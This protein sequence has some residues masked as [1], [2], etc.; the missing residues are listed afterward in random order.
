MYISWNH[1]RD[2][3][4]T[5]GVFLWVLES[6]LL[7]LFIRSL[8]SGSSSSTFL[9]SGAETSATCLKSTSTAAATPG[10]FS[11][12]VCFR[13]DKNLPN[14]FSFSA[15]FTGSLFIFCNRVRN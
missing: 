8:F 3:I 6:S 10:F 7:I 11:E 14:S 9:L 12:R 15:I 13:F 5:T 4:H 2:L 1:N